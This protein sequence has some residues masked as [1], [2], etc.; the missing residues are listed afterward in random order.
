MKI[1]SPSY[2]GIVAALSAL[3]IAPSA[4]AAATDASN[5]TLENRL[6]RI[7][8]TLQMRQQ[9]SPDTFEIP[10][11]IGKQQN[12]DHIAFSRF[13]KGPPE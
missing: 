11:S 12:G 4:E 13:I 7:T 6:Q 3:S 1:V 5:N 2:L 8:A 10:T 9:Q